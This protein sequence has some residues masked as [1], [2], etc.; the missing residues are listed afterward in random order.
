MIGPK[1]AAGLLLALLCSGCVTLE[2]RRAADEARC[3]SYGFRPGTEGFANC[4]LQVDL[5]RSAERRYQF[6]RFDADFGGGPWY[7][8]RRW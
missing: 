2:E 1:L 3:R 5:D 8:W 7:H 4:L 6:E